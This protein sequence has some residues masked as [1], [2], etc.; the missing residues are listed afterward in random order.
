MTRAFHAA[1]LTYHAISEGPAPLC[2][3]KKVR[4]L[5]LMSFLLSH[6]CS[7]SSQGA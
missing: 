3:K 1:I 6:V 4:T 5:F 2:M 7:F